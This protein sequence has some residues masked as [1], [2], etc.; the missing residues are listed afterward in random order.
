MLSQS[1]SFNDDITCHTM[2]STKLVARESFVPA[3][4]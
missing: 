1:I 2:L 4:H 3:K